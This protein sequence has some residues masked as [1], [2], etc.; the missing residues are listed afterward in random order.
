[1]RKISYVTLTSDLYFLLGISFIVYGLFFDF[2]RIG[3]ASYNISNITNSTALLISI[4]EVAHCI[5]N[6]YILH[7]CDNKLVRIIAI[8]LCILNIVYRVVNLFALVN[9]FTI[10]MLVF[11]IILLLNLIFY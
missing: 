2:T 4:A 5:I 6:A 8:I 1:M 11:G 10:I 7:K 9:L 3:S